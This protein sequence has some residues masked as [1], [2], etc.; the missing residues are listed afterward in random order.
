LVTVLTYQW[1]S[2]AR[3]ATVSTPEGVTAV[4]TNDVYTGGVVLGEES[5][6]HYAEGFDSQGEVVPSGTKVTGPAVIKPFRDK[7]HALVI[8]VGV[9]YTTTNSDEVVWLL[10]GDNACALSNAEPFYSTYEIKSQP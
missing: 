3:V 6:C 4:E 2:P 9:E 7:D 5:A 1:L 10:V 8:N